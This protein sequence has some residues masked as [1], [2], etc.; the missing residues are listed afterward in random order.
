[1]ALHFRAFVQLVV[2]CFVSF[3]DDVKRLENNGRDKRLVSVVW[4]VARL[5]ALQWQALL[6]APLILPGTGLYCSQIVGTNIKTQHED[7]EKKR[8][9]N[10]IEKKRIVLRKC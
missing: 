2:T 8:E 7:E 4:Q 6:R 9:K 1:M 5:L 10:K 3:V